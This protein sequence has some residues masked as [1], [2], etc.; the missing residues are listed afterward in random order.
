MTDH[1]VNPLNPL[2]SKISRYEQ[3]SS[4]ARQWESA[5]VEWSLRRLALDEQRKE[6]AASAVDGLYS[7]SEFNRVVSFPVVLA[8][9]PLYDSN[10]LHKNTKAIHPNWF[11]EFTKLPFIAPYEEAFES[12]K[13]QGKPVGLV[14]PRKGFAQGW[15]VHNGDWDVFVPPDSCCHIFKGGKSMNLIVQPYVTFIDN[16]KENLL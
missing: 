10:P 4:R 1:R 7:F 2:L 5:R 11:K 13:V 9:N 8:G 12:S 15:I 16:V 3:S 14:F 6:I